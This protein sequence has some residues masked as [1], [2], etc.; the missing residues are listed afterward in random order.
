M[1]GYECKENQRPP[2]EEVDERTRKWNTY[3]G[4]RIYNIKQQM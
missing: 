3:M 1:D 4:L 2:A